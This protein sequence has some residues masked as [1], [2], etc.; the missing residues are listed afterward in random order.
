[1]SW[2]KG[3]RTR[4][5]GKG[6]EIRHHAIKTDF[7]KKN[8]LANEIS[9]QTESFRLHSE[10]KESGEERPLEYIKD[11]QKEPFFTLPVRARR[12]KRIQAGSGKGHMRGRKRAPERKDACRR[13]LN[14]KTGGVRRLVVAMLVKSA[15]SYGGKKMKEALR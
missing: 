15:L 12:L 13:Q 2:L 5:T 11:T 7:S 8:H 4:R 14:K 3:R 6:K 10:I 9:G 1:V